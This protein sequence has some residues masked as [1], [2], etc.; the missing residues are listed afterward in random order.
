[1][2]RCNHIIALI[3]FECRVVLRWIVCAWMLSLSKITVRKLRS[4]LLGTD[5][6]HGN[7]DRL[8]LQSFFILLCNRGELIF[9]GVGKER[10]F[11]RVS[12]ADICHSDLLPCRRGH[13]LDE[14]A[15]LIHFASLCDE[16][17]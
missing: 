13:G 4:N 5:S 12:L 3:Q 9:R 17:E 11:P 7:L 10:A 1:M 2:L 14:L 6:L 8:W 16:L 15:G